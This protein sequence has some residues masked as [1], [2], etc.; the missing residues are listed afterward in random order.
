M[1][2]G[3][4]VL[5]KSDLDQYHLTFQRDIKACCTLGQGQKQNEL[6]GLHQPHHR[7]L[8]NGYRN[9]LES[10]CRHSSVGVT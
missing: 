10:T 5:M 4:S 6:Q 2:S 7:L 8:V 3:V 9:N 1:M